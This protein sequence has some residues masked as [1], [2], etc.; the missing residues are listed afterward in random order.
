[1]HRNI[2]PYFSLIKI[3]RL[4]F[5]TNYNANVILKNA[6]YLL[7]SEKECGLRFIQYRI[8]SNKIS[9]QHSCSSGINLVK[10]GK[11]I[12]GVIKYKRFVS[13]QYRN[14]FRRS[15]I[16][17]FP[18]DKHLLCSPDRKLATSV[19]HSLFLQ[20]DLAAFGDFITARLSN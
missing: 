20:L 6:F 4:I 13:V 2:S 7:L 17:A 9:R 16:R 1:M 5:F 18:N 19:L 10:I 15:G 3:F 8:D 11:Y 12:D 14:A